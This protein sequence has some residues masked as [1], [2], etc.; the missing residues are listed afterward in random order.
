M[1]IRARIDEIVLDGNYVKICR[2]KGIRGVVASNRFIIPTPHICFMHWKVTDKKQAAVEA[3]H[4]DLISFEDVFY[5]FHVV[6]LWNFTQ[7][8]G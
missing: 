5:D 6:Q 3:H 8:S 2:G 1:I 7:M 4:A